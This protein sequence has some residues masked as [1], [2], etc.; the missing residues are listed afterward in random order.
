MLNFSKLIVLLLV[1]LSPAVTGLSAEPMLRKTNIFAAGEADYALYRIPGVV[2]TAKGT[3]LAYCE[4]RKSDRGDWGQIDIMLRRSTDGGQGVHTRQSLQEHSHQV[5]RK[6]SRLHGLNA[7]EFFDVRLFNRFVDAL[8]HNGV[9]TEE[10]ADRL[11]WAPIVEDVLRA[12]EHII[13][14]DFR[15]AVRQEP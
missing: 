2:V 4:A 3:L 1:V 7:P 14:P 9:V 15:F 6:M 11:V 12:A 10:A 8:I 13:D 5:A